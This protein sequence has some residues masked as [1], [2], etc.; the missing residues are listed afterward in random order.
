MVLNIVNELGRAAL[1]MFELVVGLVISRTAMQRYA[2]FLN[3][4][5]FL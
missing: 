1:T 3:F 4:Q 5:T 2:L